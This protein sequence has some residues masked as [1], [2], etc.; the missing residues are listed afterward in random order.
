M[1]KLKKLG[2]LAILTSITRILGWKHG[3]NLS[4]KSDILADMKKNRF[5]SFKTVDCIEAETLVCDI[6]NLE[7]DVTGIIA[8]AF[9]LQ[10]GNLDSSV[11]SSIIYAL[12][13]FSELVR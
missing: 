2:G 1:S 3:K 5:A 8:L 13:S 11:L 4:P 10:V 7:A 12:S 6:I 9:S